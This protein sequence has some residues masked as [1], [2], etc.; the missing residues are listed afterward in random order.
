VSRSE[1]RTEKASPRRRRKAKREGQTGRS[2]EVPVALSFAGSVLVVRAFLPGAIHGLVTGTR[3]ILSVAGN[4]PPGAEVRSMVMKMT[5]SALLPFLGVATGLA[6]AG[7]L[8]QSGFSLAPAA[9]KPKLSNLSLK[10]GLQRWKPTAM[11]WEGARSGIK[12]AL[13]AAVVWGPVR[14]AMQRSGSPVGLSAWLH[15]TS[16]QATT[17]LVRLTLL[18]LVIAGADFGMNKFRTIRKLRMTKQET[19]QEHKEDEGDPLLRSQRR[20][21]HAEIARHNMIREV[22]TADV[23]LMNPTHL[24]VALRYTAGEPAPRVVAKGSGEL[25]LKL[26]STA[27]RHGVMVRV[28]KPLA[29]AI[30]RRCKVGHFVPAALFEAVAVVL[31]AAYRRRRRGAL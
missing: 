19:K 23:V 31:A 14:S 29:R 7:G 4:P 10:R 26:R 3:S 21:R 6:I 28:D 30:F 20:R 16:G 11:G 8:A 9:L 15:F 12:L 5:A 17:M 1:G 13:A 24:A 2:A 22:E 18:S 25:A 27:F